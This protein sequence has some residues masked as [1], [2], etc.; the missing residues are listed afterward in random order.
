[1]DVED[2]LTGP[3]AAVEYQPKLSV[4]FLISDV[5]RE[6]H[7]FCQQFRVRLSEFGDSGIVTDFG[8]NQYVD[9]RFRGNVSKGEQPGRLPNNV[10]RNF[11]RDNAREN[12]PSA[13]RHG[14]SLQTMTGVGPRIP[15]TQILVNERNRDWAE[16]FFDEGRGNRLPGVRGTLWAAFNGITELL[17]HRKTRQTPGQRLNSLWFSENYRLKARAFALAQ[18]KMEV[19]LS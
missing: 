1:M 13:L 15:M 2:G 5:L 6:V 18:E 12:R 19:W 9:G 11:A 3:L 14:L 7:H 16:H 10:G 17:D 4:G 8:N